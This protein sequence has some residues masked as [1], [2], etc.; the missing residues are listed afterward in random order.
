[1]HPSGLTLARWD[2]P[3]KTPQEREIVRRWIEL[4]DLDN[5]AIDF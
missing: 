3:F 1:M 2:W 4:H 5:Q